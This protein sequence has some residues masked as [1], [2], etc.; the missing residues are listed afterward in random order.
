MPCGCTIQ[1][2]SAF[3]QWLLS[4]VMSRTCIVLTLML[5]MYYPT[6]ACEGRLLLCM[7]MLNGQ[8]DT[9]VSGAPKPVFDL[10]CAGCFQDGCQ[11]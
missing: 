1:P 5:L 8:E 4:L 9:N 10:L 3:R 2:A 6:V 11:H 7:L